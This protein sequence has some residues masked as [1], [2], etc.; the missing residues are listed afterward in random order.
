MEEAAVL[1]IHAL[2]DEQEGSLSHLPENARMPIKLV[3]S[4]TV[5]IL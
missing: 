2:V 3:S 5:K 1:Y 4:C